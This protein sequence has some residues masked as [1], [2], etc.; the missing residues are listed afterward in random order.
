[1]NY[2]QLGRTPWKV[3]EISFGAWAIGGSWGTVDDTESL[4]ALHAAIDCGVNFIDTADVYGM[5]RSERLIA[6][7]LRDRKSEIVVATKA[8]PPPLAAQR[9]GLQRAE[10]HRLHRGQPAQPR[11]R[12]P[13]PGATALPAHRCL[14][15]ARTLRRAGPSGGSRQT[16]LLRRQRGARG[17]SAEGHRVSQRA[18]RADHLQ[19]LPAAPRGTLLPA[20]NGAPGRHSGAR[21]A[22][23]RNAQRQAHARLAIRGRRPPPVQSPRRSLRC[24]RDL[25][26]RRLRNRTRGRRRDPRAAARGRQH[27]AVRLALDPHAPRRHLRH[28]RRQDPVA[29]ARQ[30]RGQRPAAAHATPQ[31]M[32]YARSTIARYARPSTPAGRTASGHIHHS[33]RT[34]SLH[35]PESSHANP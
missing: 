17:R 16:A 18:D 9:R 28:P 25:L 12:L 31:C 4:A 32:P 27:G 1:M 26:R 3:S 35:Y 5:G 24:R 22:G 6:Q 13:G 8:G 21:A 29:G 7:L 2:R 34:A 15:P 23:Q 33:T 10:P 30:L 20:G 11:H 14:L 19:L